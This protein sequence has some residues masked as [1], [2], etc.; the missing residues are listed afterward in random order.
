MD[1][2]TSPGKPVALILCADPVRT[3]ALAGR[4][5]A[6]G[7]AVVTGDASE[8]GAGA[9]IRVQPRVLII[10]AGHPAAD[11]SDLVFEIAR[12]LGTT[13]VIAG[14][15]LDTIEQPVLALG[16][17]RAPTLPSAPA[18]TGAAVRSPIH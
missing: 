15:E 16:G 5:N 2:T 11:A 14:K 18:R 7:Y 13:I 8:N 1:A 4:A 6:E 9:L 12:G 17:V 10:D 3:A